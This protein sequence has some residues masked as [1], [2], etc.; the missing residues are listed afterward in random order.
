MDCSMLGF[1]V[2]HHLPEFAQT[3]VHWAS[4]VIVC[5][6]KS[7][8]ILSVIDW[9]FKRPHFFILHLCIL[10]FVNRGWQ[11]WHCTSPISQRPL[12]FHSCSL[13]T[14]TSIWISLGLPVVRW[15][16]RWGDP[17]LPE[18]N[19]DQPRASWLPI[20]KERPAK[21]SRVQLTCEWH[22]ERPEESQL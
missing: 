4:D 20:L 3:H 7:T 1:P 13:N 18:A 11:K 15:E 17:E 16:A 12:C 6:E 8:Y 5:T 10:F 9:Y 19:L 2:L 22:R 14:I 21:L